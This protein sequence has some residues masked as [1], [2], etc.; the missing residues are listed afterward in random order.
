MKYVLWL[1][2]AMACTVGYAQTS[3]ASLEKQRVQLQKD[4]KKLND[5]ISVNSKNQRSKTV[6]LQNLRS[7]VGVREKLVRNINADIGLLDRQIDDKTTETARLSRE[8]DTLRVSYAKMCSNYYKNKASGVRL[9]YILSSD[10]FLQAYRRGKYIQEYVNAIREKG[11]AVKSKNEQAQ[12]ALEDLK[13]LKDEKAALLAEQQAEVAKLKGDQAGIQKLLTALKKDKKKLENELAAKKKNAQQIQ[14]AIADIVKKEL[15]A[16]RKKNAAKGQKGDSQTPE[17]KQLSANFAQ[18]KGKLPWPVEK[19]FVYIPFGNQ[20]YPG[21]N[22]HIV[23]PGI[24]ISTPAGANARAVFSG[25][26]TRVQKNKTNGLYNVFI[27]HG[28]YYTVYGDLHSISVKEGDK[29]A[30]KQMIG[31][32]HTDTFENKTVMLFCL[33]D[34]EKEQNPETWLAR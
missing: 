16:Q 2:A 5:A 10:S 22:V 23:N 21:L 18:N 30:T 14:K 34:G 8:L 31:R 6:E 3:K 12:K 15:A 17:A 25:T 9:M 1:V 27:N 33:F 32:I 20:V 26:V 11:L 4:M 28:R 19:G 24:S 29:V 13:A 7:K